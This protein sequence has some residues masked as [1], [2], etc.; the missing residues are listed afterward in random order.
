MYGWPLAE[1]WRI[2]CLTKDT[3]MSALA[4]RLTPTVSACGEGSCASL[5]SADSR[6]ALGL[7]I[8]GRI[9]DHA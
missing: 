9:G 2:L 6:T 3:A 7:H 5:P 8:E 4:V 1:L